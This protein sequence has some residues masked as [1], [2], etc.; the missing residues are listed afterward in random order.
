MRDDVMPGDHTLSPRP[1]RGRCFGEGGGEQAQGPGGLVSIPR[2]FSQRADLDRRGELEGWPRDSVL[3]GRVG[4][5]WAA[6]SPCLAPGTFMKLFGE[7]GVG[8]L[9]YLLCC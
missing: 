9:G 1:F 5:T 3:A 2:A 4:C 7:V 6:S 8:Y